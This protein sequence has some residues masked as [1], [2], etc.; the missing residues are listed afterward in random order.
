MQLNETDKIALDFNKKIRIRFGDRVDDFAIVNVIDDPE[1][2]EF[3]VEFCAY[4]YFKVMIN[5]NKGKFDCFVCEEGLKLKLNS[6][7][8]LWETA[9]FDVFFNDIEKELELRIP[10]K[11]LDSKGWLR[12]PKGLLRKMK[13]GI[14]KNKS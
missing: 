10:D 12:K 6:S 2:R 8:E 14:R 3:G 13:I 1:C 9:D 4:D 7:Q 5:Y 11:F